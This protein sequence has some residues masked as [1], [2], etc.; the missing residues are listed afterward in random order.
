LRCW[1]AVMG[2]ERWRRG[3]VST[4]VFKLIVFFV[5]DTRSG[6]ALWLCPGVGFGCVR[7]DRER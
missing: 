2:V 1:R 6:A 3:P 4:V 7:A 5:A